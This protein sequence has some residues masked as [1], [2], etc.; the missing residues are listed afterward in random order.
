MNT[1]RAQ[2]LGQLQLTDPR[3][4]LGARYKHRTTGGRYVLDVITA[5]GHECIIYP[6]EKKQ[7]H[8]TLT[9]STSEFID[10][11]EL[12]HVEQPPE[13]QDLFAA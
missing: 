12:L 7:P 2:Q 1:I 8:I 9:W 10:A 5:D 3:L 4:H 6:V 13:T 11:F